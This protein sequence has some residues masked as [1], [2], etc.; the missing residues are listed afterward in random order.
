M[1]WSI[2]F[3]VSQERYFELP[4]ISGVFLT[5]GCQFLFSLSGFL[6]NNLVETAHNIQIFICIVKQCLS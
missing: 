1:Q 4:L 6:V 2:P 5:L 3:E